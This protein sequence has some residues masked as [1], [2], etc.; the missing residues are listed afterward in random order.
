MKDRLSEVDKNKLLTQAFPEVEGIATNSFPLT[1]N[2]KNESSE[3]S[4]QI[5]KDY[6]KVTVGLLQEVELAICSRK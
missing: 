2:Q 3:L 1:A 4:K 6:W 5:L